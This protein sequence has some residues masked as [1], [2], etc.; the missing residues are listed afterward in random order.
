M[1]VYYW[2]V[3]QI[4]LMPLDG[5]TNY[6]DA[7]VFLDGLTN[8]THASVLLDGLTN[9]T[10]ASVPLVSVGVKCCHSLISAEILMCDFLATD[11]IF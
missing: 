1:P 10:H 11:S 2:M 7:C 6:T 4:T 3:W 5:L 9:Y 8:Y